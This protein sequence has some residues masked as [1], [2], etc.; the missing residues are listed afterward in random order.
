MNTCPKA[1][2]PSNFPLLQFLGGFTAE[3]A[4]IHTHT[5]NTA[6]Y[7][8]YRRGQDH[9]ESA[10]LPMYVTQPQTGEQVSSQGQCQ[11]E[12]SSATACNTFTETATATTTD[13]YFYIT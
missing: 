11:E 2:A 8:G 9:D 5:L 6:L 1:P 4:H 13:Y 3:H 7:I 12:Y 10:M